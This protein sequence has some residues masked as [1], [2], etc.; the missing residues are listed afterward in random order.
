M[1]DKRMNTKYRTTAKM[2]LG[3]LL[4][5]FTIGSCGEIEPVDG[6]NIH[7]GANG[8]GDR[9]DGNGSDDSNGNG[10]SEQTPY[11]SI[12]GAGLRESSGTSGL[13]TRA[14]ATEKELLLQSSGDQIGIFL[15]AAPENG[16]EAISN[17][18]YTYGTPV[19]T[20]DS[21]LMLEE[22]SAQ[23]AAYYPYKPDGVTPTAVILT[24]GRYNK[25]NEFYYLPF[26]ASRISSSFRLHLRRAYSLVRLNLYVGE[27]DKATGKGAYTGDGK[28]T[29]FRFSAPLNSLGFLNLYTGEVNPASGSVS[30]NFE[31]N[32]GFTA[33]TKAVPYILDYLIVPTDLSTPVVL[34]ASGGLSTSGDLSAPGILSTSGNLSASGVLSDLSEQPKDVSQIKFTLT[35]DGKQ[36]QGSVSPQAFFGSGMK[37]LE[38]VKYET[39]V[40]IRPAG[41]DVG[42]L[43]VR[44]WETVTKEDDDD[45]QNK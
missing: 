45:L 2:L 30:V 29:A 11:L 20:S 4:V 21:H 31:E 36:M 37:L 35:V 38:G 19:W 13:V 18:K 17:K 6:T 33:G 27:E 26:K 9:N 34:S 39:N 41:L 42:T 28:V 14:D 8:D 40:V 22:N 7:T 1:N 25:A 15:Q 43:Q 12:L 23:L 3:L 16:Y 44:D 10:S 5:L 24:S 32:S